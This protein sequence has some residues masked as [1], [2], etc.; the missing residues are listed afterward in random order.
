[1]SDQP[2]RRLSTGGL[3]PIK[4]REHYVVEKASSHDSTPCYTAWVR[5]EIVQVPRGWSASDFTIQDEHP[6]MSIQIYDTRPQAANP[7][8]LKTLAETFHKE[9][10]EEREAGGREQPD[11]IDAWGMPFA[12]EASE[13]EKID[14]CKS[15][16]MA[17][18]AAKEASGDGNFHIPALR[19][20]YQWRRAILIID[21]PKEAWNEGEGGF[22][23]VYWDIHPDYL[24]ML[25]EEYGEDYQ[26]PETSV[27]R[28][29]RDEM[30]P[31]LMNLR[32]YF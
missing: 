31:L 2:E 23:V 15:H 16:N 6:Q 20:H 9:T 17:E 8:H 5:D 27:I 11:R 3:P 1:M 28:F 22:L 7:E 12:A 14:K 32:S 19:G 13:K 29:T 4:L 26:E 25:A 21:R 18:I 24:D 10:R 30:G